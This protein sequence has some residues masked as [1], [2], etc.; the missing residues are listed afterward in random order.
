MEANKT[1]IGALVILLTMG[2]YI[3]VDIFDTGEELVCRTNKPVGWEIVND[4]GDFYESVCPYSTKD[5]L[6]ANCSSFRS[7]S[8]YERYGCNEVI[9]VHNKEYKENII[10]NPNNKAKKYECNI[11]ECMVI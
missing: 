5:D 4:Y 11:K 10:D 9:V 3:A 2:G 1:L 6:Y 8:S 7:T